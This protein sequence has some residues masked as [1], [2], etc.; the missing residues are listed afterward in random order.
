MKNPFLIGSRIY[1]RPLDDSDAEGDY[2]SWLNDP[3]VCNFNAHHVFPYSKKGALSYIEHTSVSKDSIVLAVCL[4]ENDR[5]IGNISLQCINLI[6]RS[7][8]FAILMGDKDNW[9]KGFAKEASLLLLGHGFKEL[10]LH[11][12]Y[13]GTSAE[14]I[15]MQKLA[16]AIGMTQEG[17][18][19]EAM[20]KHG[21]YLDIIEFGIINNG[22]E[23][24]I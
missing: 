20:F 19:K 4:K 15:A 21:K 10:N 11:R 22:K 6:S 17:V 14:N 9:G 3:E 2:V 23:D 18:R 7:A 24:R 1:L 5:H 8:E 12:I 13:C 16:S